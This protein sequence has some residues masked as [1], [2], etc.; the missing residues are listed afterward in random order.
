MRRDERGWWHAADP[1]AGPGSRYG[2][3]LDGGPARP[4]PRSSSQPE[5][6]EGLSEVVDHS[7]FCWTDSSWRG[8]TMKGAVLYEL[9]VG[10]FTPAGTFDSAIEKLPRI[11]ELGVDAIELMPVAEFPGERGWGY[12]GVDLFAPHHAYGGPGGLKR[13]VD[14]CHGHGL[15]VVMDVVYNHLGPSGNYLG[16][17]GPYFSDRHHTNWGAAVNFDGG[18]SDEVRRFFI[19]NALGWLRDYHAD[20]LRL[21]AVHAFVDESAVHFLE[22]MAAEVDALSAHL[23]R[24]LTLIAE[25]DLNDPRFVRPAAAGGYGLDAAWADEWHH[26]LHAALTGDRSGYYEDFG[27]LAELGKA[28]R[29]AWVYDG[30][31]SA[32]RARHHGRSPAG[33]EGHRFVVFTQN[34]DQ[35]G[36]RALGERTSA[37][38]SQGR[39]RVAAALLLTGPFTPLIFQGEEWGA[40]SP[41]LYFTDHTDPSLGRAVTEGRR[42]EFSYWGTE[43]DRIPDPQA[44]AT[45]ETSK[46]DWSERDREPH[47]SLLEWYRLL[48][49]LRRRNAD[50]SDPRL[51]RVGVDVDEHNGTLVVR[52]GRFSVLVN[53]SPGCRSFGP[54]PGWELVAA[55]FPLADRS[56]DAL[57]LPPDSAAIV[58][59]A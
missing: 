13:F 49:G 5:G 9:H 29:Q 6:P 22:Q 30:V 31:W 38:M 27:G 10:T 24:P 37:L 35:V 50:L 33:L 18:G 40:G 23:R 4:D 2:Y 36:N 39:L 21:D 44:R 15:G 59:S 8:M 41:F 56:P 52:R 11:V 43:P 1:A 34:H 48:T 46:L 12:D 28:L 17:F 47:R 42:D 16:E 45:F 51:D 25:T 19:D 20:G 26:A 57:V 55:S 7:G 3:R 58:R 14:A 54:G 53:V 32:H